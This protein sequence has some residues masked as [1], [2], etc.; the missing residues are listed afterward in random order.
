MR[1]GTS[2]AEI[3]IPTLQPD[4][5]SALGIWIMSFSG[6]LLIV[7]PWSATLYLQAE[8]ERWKRETS[9]KWRR[10]NAWKC[11]GR[12]TRGVLRPFGGRACSNVAGHG[13]LS[14]AQIP[15]MESPGSVRLSKPRCIALTL[16]TCATFAPQSPP[17]YS[18]ESSRAFCGGSRSPSTMVNR[19]PKAL[20]FL[21]RVAALQ[22]SLAP[23]A[24]YL[25]TGPEVAFRL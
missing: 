1:Q 16:N 11:T 8:G 17:E 12:R 22:F 13:S 10:W 20:F 21:S 5:A 2:F 23:A 4:R 6:C 24:L 19:S 25:P 14:L 3:Q 9:N 18:S 15:K 7:S